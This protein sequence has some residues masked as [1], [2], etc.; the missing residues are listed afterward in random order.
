MD[1]DWLISGSM[2]GCATKR[3]HLS[4]DRWLLTV[5]SKIRPNSAKFNNPL[6][7]NM[8]KRWNYKISKR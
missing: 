8:T 1:I 5:I 4:K 6:Y 3:E 2:K 7:K